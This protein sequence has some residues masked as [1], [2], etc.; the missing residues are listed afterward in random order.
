VAAKDNSYNNEILD[1]LMD[2]KESNF[3]NTEYLL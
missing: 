2:S 1:A 3:V